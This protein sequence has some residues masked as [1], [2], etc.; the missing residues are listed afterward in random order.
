[1]AFTPVEI[2]A[3]VIIIFALIKMLVLLVNPKSWMNF[4]KGL[5]K[6]PAVT[7][8]IALILAAVVLYYLLQELTIVQI[9]ATMAFM[10]LLLAIGLAPEV[11][12]LIKKYETMI[13]KGN[14]WKEYWLYTLIWIILLL[15]A[16]KELFM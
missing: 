6:T 1:M 13:K 9:V 10:A 16:L 3:L 11:G 15:W 7:Q 8:I 2:I 14:L 5:Y 12:S 4:A